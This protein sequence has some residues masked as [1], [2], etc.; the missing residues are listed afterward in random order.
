MEKKEHSGLKKF[1][2]SLETLSAFANNCMKWK[3]A[4]DSAVC[5][6]GNQVTYN[7]QQPTIGRLRV[8]KGLSRDEEVFWIKNYLL[9]PLAAKSI[10]LDSIFI[11]IFV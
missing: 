7:C 2:A 3:K 1:T 9:I 5:A 8:L 11:K 4:A 10:S 6:V